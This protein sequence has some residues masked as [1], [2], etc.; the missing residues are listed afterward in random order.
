[1]N[2][3]FEIRSLQIQDLD[4]MY[5]AF[6]EAFSDYQVNFAISREQFNRRFLGKLNLDFKYSVGAFHH[7]N[8]V[9]FIFHTINNYQGRPMLYNGGTGVVPPMRGK[10][11]VSH[12]YNNVK[13]LVSEQEVPFSVLEVITTNNR[14]IS[15]YEKVGFEIARTLKCFKLTRAP[16]TEINHQIYLKVSQTLA[17][18]QYKFGDYEPSFIDTLQQLKQNPN[19]SVIEAYY[20]GQ[21]VGYLILQTHLGRISQLAVDK[22]FRHK[23]TASTLVSKAWE[24]SENKQLTLLNVDES[25]FEMI[26]FLTNRGFENQLD[27]YEMIMRLK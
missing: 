23:G 11:I 15:A 2:H 21:L 20:N 6:L 12:L 26:N 1:M 5:T 9:G 13:K 18:D 27:Q 7:G 14:A 16:D 22:A 19:E 24:I 8:L 10:G 17:I 25:E 3:D 4:Q